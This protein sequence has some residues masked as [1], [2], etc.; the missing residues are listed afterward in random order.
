MATAQTPTLQPDGAANV[1]IDGQAAS[2]FR[3]P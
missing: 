2:L 3:I 1:G